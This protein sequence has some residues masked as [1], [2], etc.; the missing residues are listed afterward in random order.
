M[1]IYTGCL[2]YQK[3]ELYWFLTNL[4]CSMEKEA[5]YL[6]KL[7][8]S[9]TL[10]KP[11]SSVGSISD[12]RTGVLWFNPRLG[13]YSLRGLMIT[14]RQDS[15]LSHLCPLFRLWLCGK[16]ASGLERML[17]TVLGP[18]SP[19]ILKNILCLCLQDLQI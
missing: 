7:Y 9:C 6:S 17:C 1:E 16:A 8:I 10:K 5:I 12:L 3:L 4:T 14:L 11:H 13:Q 2:N 19:T 18:Y 15:F